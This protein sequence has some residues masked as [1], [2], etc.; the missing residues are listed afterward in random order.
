MADRRETPDILGAVLGGDA[1]EATSKTVSQHDSKPAKRQA[2]KPATAK[3]TATRP[4]T[5]PEGK[6][7]K[8]TF[9]LS[10]ETLEKLEDGLYQLRKAGTKA[11]KSGL[12]EAALV[13]GLAE[14]EDKG[15]K[16]RVAGLLAGSL[17]A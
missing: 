8:A 15:P 1:P 6:P 12:V 4:A 7:V 9:Y 3:K 14:L 13:A 10:P 17:K 11:T 5:K 16:S 2:S